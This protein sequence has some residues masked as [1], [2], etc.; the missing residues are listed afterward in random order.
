MKLFT[1]S[2]PPRIKYGVNSSG[3]PDD[4]PAE[5]GNYIKVWIPV[6]TG[7]T[8]HKRGQSDGGDFC[9]SRASTR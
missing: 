7:M 6:F 2:F 9:I 8:S 4:I 1:S 5:A 3:N